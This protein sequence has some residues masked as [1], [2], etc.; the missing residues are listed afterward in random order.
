MFGNQQ[1]SRGTDLPARIETDEAGSARIVRSPNAVIEDYGRRKAMRA[2]RAE[3]I[4][5]ATAIE[6][7]WR[8]VSVYFRS[9]RA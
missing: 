4:N 9:E 5:Q 6:R 7:E 8:R 2:I 1:I 3:E